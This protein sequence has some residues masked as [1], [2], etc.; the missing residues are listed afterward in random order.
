ML[1]VKGLD[2]VRPWPVYLMALSVPLS[3]AA[4][5]LAKLL[6]VLFALSALTAHLVRRQ[7]VHALAGL[8]APR[9][10][11]FMLAALAASI[12]YADA[13]LADAL[14][15]FA[16]YAKLLVIPLVLVLV[17]TR[18]EALVA[19]AFYAVAQAFVLATSWLLGLGLAV[20]WVPAVRTSLA[21]VYSS[22]LDQSIMTAG[23]A[24]LCW[25]LRGEFPG[26]RGAQLAMA[27]AVLAVINVMFL[28][29][30]RS[31]HVCAIVVISLAVFWATPRR[32]RAASVF[33]PVVLVAGALL[34]SPKFRDR[35]TQVVDESRAYSQQKQVMTSSGL[36]LNLW[37]SAV[38]AMAERPLTGYGV[39]SWSRQ[40]LRLDQGRDR[41]YIGTGGN[42]HQE[43]LL[44]GVHLGVPGLL[45]LVAL[46]AALAWDARR[47]PPA[48]R[49]GALSITAMLAAAC[50]FNSSLFDALIG[51]YFCVL[52]GLLFALG[53][54]PDAGQAAAPG[55]AAG[56]TPGAAHAGA[57]A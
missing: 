34:I 30:G 22:Y 1:N 18:R 15:G 40:Y 25:H 4:T 5:S 43:Y 16:K 8:Y 28:L 49:H 21:T 42:P 27:L 32:W 11:L 26:R 3:M 9:V 55:A 12:S 2:T 19:L 17:R 6:L 45:L 39:G 56:S 31:G 48:V 33:F 44:W 13:S 24:A 41:N 23:F 52:L 50:L 57:A 36:R 37:K 20:P 47:L 29:P 54:R 35:I 46:L 51:D 53:L 10:I 14:G 38:E 7:G